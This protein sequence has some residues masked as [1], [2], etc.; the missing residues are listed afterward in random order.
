MNENI[1]YYIRVLA[2]YR[3]VLESSTILLSIYWFIN[4][5]NQGSHINHLL[6]LILNN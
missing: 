4:Y 5:V 1:N 6:V 2:P 3:Y